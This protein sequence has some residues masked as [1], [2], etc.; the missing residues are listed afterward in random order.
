MATDPTFLVPIE[1]DNVLLAFPAD[2]MRLLPKW[3]DIPAEFKNPNRPTKWN[4][5]FND[6]F[7]HGLK[8][9]VRKPKPGIDELKAIRH[10][11]C[12]VGS[13]EP[14]HQHK[15]A[16]VAYLMSLWFDD[17]LWERRDA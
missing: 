1:V 7:Y 15:E 12:I 16:G 3:E 11:S 10:L 17:I 2:V 13:Y 6:W 5:L 4:N 14:K 9:L 8:S